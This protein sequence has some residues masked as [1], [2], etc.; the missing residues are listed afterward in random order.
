MLGAAGRGRA[1]RVQPERTLHRLSISKEVFAQYTPHYREVEA[2]G[3]SV[4]AQALY[5][6][7]LGDWCSCFL[8]DLRGVDAMDISI[9]N[10]LKDSLSKV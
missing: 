10:H 1:L 2:K 8:A 4:L 3:A 9:I 6:V 5:A 7:H